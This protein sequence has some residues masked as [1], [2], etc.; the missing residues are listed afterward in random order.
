MPEPLEG[1]YSNHI[2]IGQNAF[3]FVVD[4]GQFYEEADGVLVH[5]RVVLSPFYA[6]HFS[7]LLLDSVQRYEGNYGAIPSEEA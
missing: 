1:R 5:T 4:F 2:E 7:E 3:E 6:K